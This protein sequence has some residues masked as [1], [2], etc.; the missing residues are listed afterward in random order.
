MK[1]GIIEQIDVPAEIILNPATEYVAKFT[2]EVPRE[3]VLTCANVMDEPTSGLELSSLRVDQN[4]VIETVAEAV[5]NE[6][7]PVAVV[8]KKDKIVGILN[9]KTIIHILF[10]KDRSPEPEI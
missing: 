2:R 5:L 4:A 7:K 6:N 1:D 9:N 8:D 3:R 10:G